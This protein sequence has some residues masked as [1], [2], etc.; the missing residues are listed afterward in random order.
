MLAY[1]MDG[2]RYES[3]HSYL[4]TQEG[5]GEKGIGQIQLRVRPREDEHQNEA[6]QHEAKSGK[7]TPDPA[8]PHHSEVDAQLVGFGTGKHLING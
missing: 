1:S 7:K 2:T 5:S 6:R 8:S 3:D 4:N